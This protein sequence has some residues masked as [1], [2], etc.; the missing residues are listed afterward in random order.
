[1]EAASLNFIRQTSSLEIKERVHVVVLNSN[2]TGQQ[3]G[4]L[5]RVS[6]LHHEVKF[7]LLWEISVFYLKAFN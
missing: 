5:G 7:L 6:M 1:M 4:K 3:D 2:S